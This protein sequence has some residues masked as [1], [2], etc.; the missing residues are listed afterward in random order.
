MILLY[1]G[2]YPDQTAAIIEK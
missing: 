2:K 1:K